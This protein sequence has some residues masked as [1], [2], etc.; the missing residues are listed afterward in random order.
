M[1]MIAGF[2]SPIETAYNY[3]ITYI[4][5]NQKNTIFVIKKKQKLQAVVQ[6][7]LHTVT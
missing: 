4:V 7:T 1:E 3:N 5:D 6:H 2:F